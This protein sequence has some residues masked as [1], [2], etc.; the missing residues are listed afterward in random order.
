MKIYL[1]LSQIFEGT[2]FSIDNAN[3]I[4]TDTDFSTFDS[5]C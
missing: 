5:E 2:R 4:R 1:I 3:P